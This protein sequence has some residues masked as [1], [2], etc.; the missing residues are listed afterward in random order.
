M[1][2]GRSTQHGAALFSVRDHDRQL[3]TERRHVEHFRFPA[4]RFQDVDQAEHF[5]GGRA[6]ED[7]AARRDLAKDG[8][9]VGD[10]GP[11]DPPQ[12][13][14]RPQRHLP[15]DG[16]GQAHLPGAAEIIRLDRGRDGLDALQPLP[17]TVSSMNE[18]VG[19]GT[20]MAGRETRSA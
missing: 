11:A 10:H 16:A 4:A 6:E 19:P 17:P 14:E 1:E 13:L 18:V 15:Y 3:L 12:P 5:R 20:T 8:L 2:P 9:R 7:L